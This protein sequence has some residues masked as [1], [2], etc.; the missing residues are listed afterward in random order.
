M[1]TSFSVS[2][3]SMVTKIND[4]LVKMPPAG[5]W[6]QARKEPEGCRKSGKPLLQEEN[7]SGEPKGKVLCSGDLQQVYLIDGREHFLVTQYLLNVNGFPGY[8][9]FRRGNKA[10]VLAKYH[11]AAT[12]DYRLHGI[13]SDLGARGQIVFNPA[14]IHLNG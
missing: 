9:F 14:E 6:C 1:I 8:H 5:F 2:D 4:L 7:F 13:V 11:K 3:Y 10:A 12:T